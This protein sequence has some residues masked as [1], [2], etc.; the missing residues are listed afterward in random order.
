ML[1]A[2]AEAGGG[3]Y[4]FFDVKTKHN[5]AEKASRLYLKELQTREDD[6]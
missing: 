3:A 2:L 6:V 5:W 4:E 1:R